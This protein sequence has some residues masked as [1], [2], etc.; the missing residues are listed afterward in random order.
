MKAM[1][2]RLVSKAGMEA[3]RGVSILAGPRTSG[4]DAGPTGMAIKIEDG[5]GYDRGTWAASVEALVQA[6]VL[7]GQPLRMLARY[8]RPVSMDPHGR[9]GAEAVA[10]FDLAP[11]GELV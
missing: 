3:L 7:E 8:H 10:T 2:G 1:P 11:L 4:S 9:V 5:D 6:G